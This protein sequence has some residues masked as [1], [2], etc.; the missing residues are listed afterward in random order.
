MKKLLKISTLAL[1]MLSLFTTSCEKADVA[2][3]A[4]AGEIKVTWTPEYSTAPVTTTSDIKDGEVSKEYKFEPKLT[5]PLC[6]DGIWSMD[7]DKPKDAFVYG[8]NDPK[9]GKAT[10][11]LKTKGTYKFTFTYKCPGCKAVSL[12]ISITVS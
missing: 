12:S 10:L 11:T 7:I 8:V 4:P 6:P 5:N 9:T 1:V 2:P 3:E